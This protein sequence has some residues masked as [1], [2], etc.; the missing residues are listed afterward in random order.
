MSHRSRRVPLGCILLL[1]GVLGAEAEPPGLEFRGYASSGKDVRLSIARRAAGGIFQTVWMTL[2]EP[3]G[4][5]VVRAFDPRAET[6]LVVHQGRNSLLGLKRAA[7]ASIAPTEFSSGTSD[8]AEERAE[9]M[10]MANEIGRSRARR[11]AE[12]A[13]AAETDDGDGSDAAA[14]GISRPGN[15][16]DAASSGPEFERSQ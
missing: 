7:I 9:R 14:P 1:A 3:D 15:T 10:E 16:T 6:V 8:S 11:L 2:N 4:G 12:L 13:R 5:W